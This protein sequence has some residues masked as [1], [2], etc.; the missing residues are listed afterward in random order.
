[1]ISRFIFT[2]FL[3]LSFNLHA[4]DEEGK[5]LPPRVLEVIKSHEKVWAKKVESTHSD[6]VRYAKL[7]KE[8]SNLGHPTIARDYFRRSITSG[9]GQNRTVVYL[10]YISSEISHFKRSDGENKETLA[11]LA[12]EVS[13]YMEANPQFE[14]KRLRRFLRHYY[15]DLN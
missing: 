4:E 7:A 1:M 15:E 14:N 5:K 2:V 13:L 6:F 10:N 9:N 12:R 8:I 3:V 11:K